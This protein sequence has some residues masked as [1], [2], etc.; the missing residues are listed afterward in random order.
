MVDDFYLN[1]L[2]WSTQNAVAVAL[3][4]ATYVWQADSGQVS[5]LGEAPE[6]TYVSSVDFS[7]D[8][9][10]LGVGISNGTVELWDI[11]TQQKLRSM[12]GHN[13]QIAVLSWNQHILSSGCADGSIWH[14]DVRVSQHKV[15][16]L[17]GHSGEVCGLKWRNDGELLASGGNDN[18]VNIW[19]G[20][21]VDAVGGDGT[22]ARGNAKWTKR[23]HTAAVKA[24]AWCPWQPSLLA[25]GGGTNDSTINIWNSTTGARLH[26]L[27]TP[28]QITSLHFSPTRKE[29][30]STHGY[31]TNSIMIHAYPSME[32]VAEIRDAHDSR[33]LFSAV[34]PRGEVVCTGA[35]DENLKFWR[36]WESTVESGGGKKRSGKGAG[37]G[38]VGGGGRVNSTREGILSI[39]IRG[40]CS[41]DSEATRSLD[42]ISTPVYHFLDLAVR[43]HHRSVS[44][45]SKHPRLELHHRSIRA[46]SSHRA[47][48]SALKN[49]H[50][51]ILPSSGLCFPSTRTD[52]DKLYQHRRFFRVMAP[53]RWVVVDDTDVQEGITYNGNWF[54][55]VGSQDGVGNFGPPYLGTLHGITTNGSL[56]FP[57]SGTA[58][59]VFGTNNETNF[60]TDPDPTWECFIDDISISR[61]PPSQLVENNW[62]FCGTSGLPD[63]N[64]TLKV[65]VQVKS[66]SQT[67]WFDKIRYIPSPS[68]SLENR[69]IL[70]DSSD[71]AVQYDAQWSALG[72]NANMTTKS[73]SIATVNFVGVSVSWYA[74]I[75]TELPHNGTR[76]SWSIDGGQDNTFTLKGLR[77]GAGVSTVFN[78]QYFTTPD[79]PAGS[80]TLEVKFL[81]SEQTTPLCIDYLYIKNGSFPTLTDTTSSGASSAGAGSSSISSPNRQPDTGGASKEIPL[82]AITSRRFF[83][84]MAPDRWVV[85]DDADVEG[86]ITYNGNWFSDTGSQNNVGNFGPPYLG[87]LHGI[88]TNGFLSFPFSGTAVQVWGTNNE[89]NFNTDPDPTWECFI[90]GNSISRDAPFQ[91]AENN[92]KFCDKSGLPMVITP[93]ESRSKSR[94]L[95]KRSGWTKYDTSL[96]RF[97]AQWTSLGGG[98]NMTTKPGSIATVNF[99]GES[100]FERFLIKY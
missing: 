41:E 10:F 65:N 81:G 37:V 6:G 16:E 5:A 60:N 55:D 78:Q 62:K 25:S 40:L 80:H 20:R 73:S 85:V 63:G 18:V 54:R 43:L 79:L 48:N 84:V 64:H 27:A 46:P 3:E 69:T 31:P 56:S 59:D 52:A 12:S 22:V 42:R 28:S 82:G 45:S 19:D 33:V 74:Y 14:H 66:P 58:V 50:S 38:E 17:L 90:D 1:L 88:T 71:P 92:W 72:D 35:G 96:H 95:R 13:G 9:S 30:L 39:R 67:F 89:A 21:I 93:Y 44:P 53:G 94:I 68:L 86:G 4:T 51:R 57:F 77:A 83:R 91:F 87:T 2:S 32:R 97:D 24:L 98:A 100:Y 26:T 99:V 7:N 36:V 11:S 29:L 34:D 61:Y 70:V 8:G 76:A 15:M 23:N 47:T 49:A 75:P